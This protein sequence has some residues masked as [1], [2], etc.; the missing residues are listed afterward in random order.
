M[1]MPVLV[2]VI[3]VVMVLIVFSGWFYHLVQGVREVVLD[4]VFF[5]YR[6]LGVSLVSIF[7]MMMAFVGIATINEC[8][9]REGEEGREGMFASLKCEEY[10]S[11]KAST[12]EL[13][14]TGESTEDNSFK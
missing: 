10:L 14:Q 2:G 6:V 1:Q 12:D 8:E 3:L 13:F 9:E 7:I 4:D 5:N 11:L